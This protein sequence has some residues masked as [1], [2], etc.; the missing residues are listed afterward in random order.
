MTD[1]M[2]GSVVG[3]APLSVRLQ[4]PSG[5][6]V[7]VHTT[8][9][10][11][12]AF[13]VHLE[14]REHERRDGAPDRVRRDRL[15]D[16]PL[17]LAHPRRLRHQLRALGAHR[18][19][20]AKG[21]QRGQLHQLDLP[22]D[23]R[24]GALAVRRDAERGEPAED[25]G[26]NEGEL[27]RVDHQLSERRQPRDGEQRS[28]PALGHSQQPEPLNGG[29]LGIVGE[30]VCATRD[31]GL[32]EHAAFEDRRV[33]H[34]IGQQPAQ[35]GALVLVLERL[36]S[37]RFLRGEG[38]L[39]A[40]ELERHEFAEGLPSFQEPIREG[41]PAAQVGWGLRDP[42]VK[43]LLRVG[44][45][46][47]RWRRRARSGR[48]RSEHQ[49]EPA[50]PTS[51]GLEPSRR[52]EVRR[53]SMH[54]DQQPSE[55]EDRCGR[56]ELH[57]WTANELGSRVGDGRV[58][59]KVQQRQGAF[60]DVGRGWIAQPVEEEG[61]IARAASCDALGPRRLDL[62]ARSIGQ[63]T[64]RWPLVQR[65]EARRRLRRVDRRAQRRA[66]ATNDSFPPLLDGLGDVVHRFE[67]LERLRAAAVHPEAAQGGGA[68]AT[69]MPLPHR[70]APKERGRGLADSTIDGP[71]RERLEA[72]LQL[73]KAGVGE[74]GEQLTEP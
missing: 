5:A 35:P 43:G 65:V 71:E 74:R 29:E 50:E 39:Q 20:H 31:A 18:P 15:D 63:G 72:R 73:G 6:R 68:R 11:V 45:A 49:L 41:V 25:V 47:G 59:R 48:S 14:H 32:C 44:R 28:K 62:G 33:T 51:G 26:R 61:E 17:E 36:H 54:R 40:G 7:N 55:G 8:A 3:K 30:R 10:P 69:L 52:L 56:V 12:G 64:Q 58:A 24:P 38:P 66:S 34:Q 70:A 42:R 2:A 22:A 21:L 67:R 16:Q 46:N 57:R 1:R 4:E 19:Q 37:L 60:D 13:R 53:I 9:P 23:A 27:L